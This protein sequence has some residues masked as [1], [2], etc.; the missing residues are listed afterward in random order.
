MAGDTGQKGGGRSHKHWMEGANGGGK[1]GA[2][3]KRLWLCVES[4]II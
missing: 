4:V 1:A 3:Q 2:A